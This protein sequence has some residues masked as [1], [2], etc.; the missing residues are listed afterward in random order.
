[1]S[2]LAPCARFIGRPEACGH[3]RRRMDESRR[4]RF[5]ARMVSLNL[6][7]LVAAYMSG[8][9]DATEHAKGAV[10]TFWYA[11]HIG[12]YFAIFTAAALSIAGLVVILQTPGD[13][14]RS[15]LRGNGLLL[16]LVIANALGFTGAPLD[17]WWH[18]T[19]G[20][21]LTVWSP[22]HLHL[23]AGMVLA[24]LACA[25][26]FAGTIRAGDSITTLPTGG[27]ISILATSVAIL[28]AAYLF[29][30]YEAGLANAAVRERPTWTYPVLWTVFATFAVALPA[31][32]CRFRWATTAIA[33]IYCVG[34]I[35]VL[36]VDR[37]VLDFSGAIPY[38]LVI[39]AVAFD[40]GQLVAEGRA[41]PRW[42]S[43]MLA[44]TAASISVIVS[45]PLFWAAVGVLPNL[46]VQPWAAASPAA[47][48]AGIAGGFAGAWSGAK[49]RHHRPQGPTE[50]TATT[51]GIAA[52][53]P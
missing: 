25:V 14:L 37:S 38:P 20:I 4:A 44:G 6:V 15:K 8:Q 11:P 50:S 12:I 36:V 28:L 7:A 32:L 34:R 5:V 35:G 47:L 3:G 31:N 21:D 39:P 40:A 41:L 43:T 23:L 19:F 48:A 2:V 27:W 51:A 13:S 16:I 52:P 45:A 24:A 30:E 49:L 33:T 17:A 53:E 29:F 18:Q 9:W 22:P 1:M 26:Y 42:G 10:D 46:N